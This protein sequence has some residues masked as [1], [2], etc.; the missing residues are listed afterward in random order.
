M[1]SIWLKGRRR[2]SDTA[3]QL[4]PD[5][6]LLELWR[7]GFYYPGII[8]RVALGCGRMPIHVRDRKLCEGPNYA[9]GDR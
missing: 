1:A 3:L 9:D 5:R 8:S 2:P 6:H 4:R 7:A